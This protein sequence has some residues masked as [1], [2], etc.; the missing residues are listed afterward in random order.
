MQT[1]AISNRSDEQNVLNFDTNEPPRKTGLELVMEEKQMRIEV[2]VSEDKKETETWSNYAGLAVLLAH[3]RAK[4]RLAPLA[5]LD[6][7]MQKRDFS[8][9]DKLSQV[10]LSI[11]MG[12]ESL[13]E[14]KR[15]F[16][17]EKALAQVGGWERFADQSSLSRTLDALTLKQIEQLRQSTTTIW[18]QASQIR[19]RDWRGFLWLDFDLSGLP[20]AAQAEASQKGYFSEKKRHWASVSPGE[21]H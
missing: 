16:P 11:L 1:E 6:N 12:C 20:C 7:V 18:R 21:C 3:Y 19:Q 17:S 8:V 9:S 14:T 2:K 10:L 13:S 15:V 4:N 5:S